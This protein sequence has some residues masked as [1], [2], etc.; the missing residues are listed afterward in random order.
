MK[1]LH[2]LQLQLAKLKLSKNIKRK[3][4][5]LGEALFWKLEVRRLGNSTIGL[6]NHLWE[7]QIKKYNEVLAL[8]NIDYSNLTNFDVLDIG[9]GPFPSLAGIRGAQI[10]YLDPLFE[11]YINSR[12]PILDWQSRFKHN[13]CRG[14]GEYIPMKNN[15]FDL[16]LMINSLDHTDD[17]TKV[18]WELKRVVKSDGIII[19]EVAFHDQTITEPVK[20]DLINLLTLCDSIFKKTSIIQTRNGP[21]YFEKTALIK[22]HS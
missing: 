1:I 7:V 5:Y 17:F 4:K 2:I 22:I 6:E 21:R 8:S 16:I 13:L 10:T 19:I 18:L 11:A 14:Q 3:I 20:L 12:Y 9:S 15:S